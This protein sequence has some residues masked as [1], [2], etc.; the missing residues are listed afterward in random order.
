M[1]LFNATRMEPLD[2][3]SLSHGSLPCLPA[4]QMSASAGCFA[5]HTAR[6]GEPSAR[7]ET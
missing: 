4:R 7:R 2:A 3:G 6:F 1:P 5:R